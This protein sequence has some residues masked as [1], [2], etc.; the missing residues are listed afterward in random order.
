M[1]Y[2]KKSNRKKTFKDYKIGFV[3]I[4]ITK[5]RTSEGKGYLFVASDRVTK[6]VYAELQRHM[7]AK[8]C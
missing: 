1:F 3:Y 8:H 6:H 5:V 4:G 7:T 2:Q